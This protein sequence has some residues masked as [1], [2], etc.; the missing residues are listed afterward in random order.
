MRG[1]LQSPPLVP[2]ACV[3]PRLL[4]PFVRR[5][6]MSFSLPYLALFLPAQFMTLPPPN[7][8]TQSYRISGVFPDRLAFLFLDLFFVFL[9]GL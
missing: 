8:L 5:R 4:N 1:D 9:P 7:F 6:R 2:L 3:I